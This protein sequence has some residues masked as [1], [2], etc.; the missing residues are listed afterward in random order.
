[1]IPQ[2]FP[3]DYPKDKIVTK[4]EKIIIPSINSQIKSIVHECGF[5]IYRNKIN[6]TLERRAVLKNNES[7]WK[8]EIQDIIDYS[9]DE[10]LVLD[11]R[12]DIGFPL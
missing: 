3:S 6:N 5:I 9:L 10:D 2:E 12:M 4:E 1:M 8:S 11:V 7:E